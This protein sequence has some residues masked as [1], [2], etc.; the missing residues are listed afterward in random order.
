MQSAN[1]N[2]AAAFFYRCDNAFTEAGR[3]RE[4]DRAKVSSNFLT[5]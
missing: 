5:D 4:P 1:R 3:A 2:P